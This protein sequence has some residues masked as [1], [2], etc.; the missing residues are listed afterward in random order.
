[1][2]KTTTMSDGGRCTI[3]YKARGL[4]VH[5]NARSTQETGRGDPKRSARL[6]RSRSP[7][8]HAHRRARTARAQRV[9][10]ALSAAWQPPRVRNS[11][12][13]SAP[14]RTRK[15]R[16]PAHMWHE[17]NHA[18]MQLS[19]CGGFAPPPPASIPCKRSVASPKQPTSPVRVAG[20]AAG[21]GSGARGVGE[22]VVLIAPLLKRELE[23]AR[24]QFRLMVCSPFSEGH[25][26]AASLRATLDAF[27]GF[28][29]VPPVCHCN[30]SPGLPAST[31][32]ST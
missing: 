4:T 5:A 20:A 15:R 23:R 28:S 1:M 27:F 18:H 13:N 7:H 3:G 24:G 31:L 6:R 22:H 17:R 32:S 2:T 16:R 12:R 19:A 29:K 8:A 11:P 30:T 14:A 26:D 9:P 25:A 21:A 10:V